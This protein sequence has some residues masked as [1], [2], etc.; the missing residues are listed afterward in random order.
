MMP[1]IHLVPILAISTLLGAVAVPV[2]PDAAGSSDQQTQ[3]AASRITIAVVLA[4]T[5][6]RADARAKVIRRRE[7]PLQN[8]IVVTPQTSPADLQRAVIAVATAA[9][10]QGLDTA[11]TAIAYIGQGRPSP[12]AQRGENA[13]VARR[14]KEVNQ[15]LRALPAAPQAQIAGYGSARTVIY[16]TQEDHWVRRP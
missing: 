5:L 1:Q 2:G 15:I 16:H 4:E 12:A 8:I 9:A 11:P 6:D 3:Q 10:R 14:L 7:Q 13:L